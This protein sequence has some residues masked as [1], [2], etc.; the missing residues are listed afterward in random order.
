MFRSVSDIKTAEDLKLPTPLLAERED[1]K[2]MPRVVV[3]PSGPNMREYKE[4][5]DRRA[6]RLTGRSGQGGDNHLLIVNDG[7]KAAVDLRMVGR[8]PDQPSKLAMVADNIARIWSD[9]KEQR[10]P[11]QKW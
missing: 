7:K 3:V 2:R 9:T 4:D 10:V 1:G 8:Q 11:D 6:A 5:T